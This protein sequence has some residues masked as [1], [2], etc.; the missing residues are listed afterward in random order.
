MIDPK[1]AKSVQ[2]CLGVNG[3]SKLHFSYARVSS[4][5]EFFFPTVPVVH[6]WFQILSSLTKMAGCRGSLRGFQPDLK[7]FRY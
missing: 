1:S 4:M 5:P 6:R 7:S 2:W 3:I